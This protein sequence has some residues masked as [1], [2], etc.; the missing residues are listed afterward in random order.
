M[1][2]HFENFD[3][4]EAVKKI[5]TRA[6]AGWLGM[7]FHDAGTDW[8]ELRLPWRDDLLSEKAPKTLA[9]GP[10]V[11]LLDMA[12]GMCIWTKMGDY[13]PVATLDL[14]IDYQRS[15]RD[16]NAVIGRAECFKVTRS[17]AFVRGYA[18]DGNPD[19]PIA[20]MAGVFMNVKGAPITIGDCQNANL[21]GEDYSPYARALGVITAGDESGVP[22]L[23]LPFSQITEGRQ[24]V[25]HG[26]ATA[27]LLETAG[28]AGLRAYLNAANRTTRIK[29]IN[30]TIQYLAPAR[31][32]AIY[33]RAHIVKLGRRS[34]NVTIEAWQDNRQ[35]PVASAVMNFLL[36]DADPA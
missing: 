24:S 28:Y 35:R 7:G 18:H 33:A 5:L 36:K 21:E 11:S 16:G 14:R 1:T 27:G 6:H 26:G 34:A 32:Q 9:T 30:V 20:T 29:P 2:T 17:A 13:F 12:S 25:F 31:S 10:I 4:A 3:P 22:I 19:D 15:A 23:S 8:V